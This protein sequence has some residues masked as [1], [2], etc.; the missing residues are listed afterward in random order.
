ML[1]PTVRRTWAPRGRT[2]VLRSWD[3]HDRLSVL[4]AITVSPVRR[5]LGLYWQ[6][7]ATNVCGVDVARF[8]RVLQRAVHTRLLVVLD[9]LNAHKRAARLVAQ[10]PVRTCHRLPPIRF[11]WLPAYAPELDPVEHV[12]GHTKRDDLAN[13]L[14]DDVTALAGDLD[15][16]LAHTSTEQALLLGFFRLAQLPL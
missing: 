9:R 10:A 3:R 11:E 5:Q 7:Q 4:G 8:I 16:S 2:P 15:M 14:P 12:W 6:L 13:Y 1:Q